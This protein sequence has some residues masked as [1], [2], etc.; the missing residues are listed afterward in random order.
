M[1]NIW[2]RGSARTLMQAQSGGDHGRANL[3]M[4]MGAGLAGL[5]S[6]PT[7]TAFLVCACLLRVRL[8]VTPML[9]NPLT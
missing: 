6:A 3:P 9:P 8:G 2:G 1:D 4:G 5:G 7:C